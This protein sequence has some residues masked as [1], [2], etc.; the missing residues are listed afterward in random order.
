MEEDCSNESLSWARVSR[1]AG[2]RRGAGDWSVNISAYK[3]M[4]RNVLGCYINTTLQAA[5]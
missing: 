2:L 5:S 3:G 1:S 4:T